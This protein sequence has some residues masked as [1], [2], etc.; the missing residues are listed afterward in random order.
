LEAD[1]QSISAEEGRRQELRARPAR[2]AGVAALRGLAEEEVPLVVRD[3]DVELF[4][5]LSGLNRHGAAAV[6]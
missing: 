4:E 6:I 2:D 1:N 3:A 5:L